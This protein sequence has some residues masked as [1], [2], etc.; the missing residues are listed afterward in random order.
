MSDTEKSLTPEDASQRG[1]YEEDV[2]KFLSTVDEPGLQRT[3]SDLWDC[4]WRVAPGQEGEGALSAREHWDVLRYELGKMGANLADAAGAEKELKGE[5]SIQ[6]SLR[7]GLVELL[8]DL[9]F[10][11][12][13]S[14]T[15]ETAPFAEELLRGLT[16]NFQGVGEPF[17]AARAHAIAVI[18]DL[19][20]HP[21]RYEEIRELAGLHAGQDSGWEVRSESSSTGISSGFLPPAMSDDSDIASM[22]QPP[23][24][25]EEIYLSGE[26]AWPRSSTWSRPARKSGRK[27][28]GRAEKEAPEVRA[29]TEPE[30]EDA[31]HHRNLRYGQDG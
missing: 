4:L 9:N 1:R 29:E 5:T 21:E 3:V 8:T 16:L 22:E 6:R 25:P 12:L 14:W 10:P 15:G 2:E 23:I 31:A 30:H 28:Q 17:E 13:D 20:L 19:I 18:R 27:A 11:R 7:E 26:E 24:V